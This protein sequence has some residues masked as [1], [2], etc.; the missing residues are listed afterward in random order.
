MS[1]KI[2]CCSNPLPWPS[3]WIGVIDTL[4][5]DVRGL[6]AIVVG[7]GVGGQLAL[8]TQSPIAANVGPTAGGCVCPE[9]TRT[10]GLVGNI[11]V[12]GTGAFVG[13]GAA[14]GTGAF[15]G[16]T[17]AAMPPWTALNALTRPHFHCVPVPV[18][19]SAVLHSLSTTA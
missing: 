7:S 13:T 6:N 3:V 8:V 2:I 17:A 19:L 5:V 10:G 16:V 9:V 18:I 1:S 15:V 12:V 14:V 4:G 11:A